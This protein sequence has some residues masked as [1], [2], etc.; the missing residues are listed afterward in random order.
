M[1]TNVSVVMQHQYHTVILIEHISYSEAIDILYSNNLFYFRNPITNW[2]FSTWRVLPKRLEQVRIV[3]LDE[4]IG[5]PSIVFSNRKQWNRIWRTLAKMTRLKVLYLN[6]ET[7]YPR[8]WGCELEKRLLG[9]LAA[10]TQVSELCVIL[11]WCRPAGLEDEEYPSHVRENVW[12]LDEYRDP[13][14]FYAAC[15][16][17]EMRDWIVQKLSLL[18][19][20]DP[21]DRPHKVS[22]KKA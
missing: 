4:T 10:V 21:V 9:P 15:P 22:N 19:L 5:D 14:D 11:R 8:V 20:G 17:A 7:L 13:A 1:S 12:R 16:P 18:E 3:V 2:S 6:V